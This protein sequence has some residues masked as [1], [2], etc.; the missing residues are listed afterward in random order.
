MAVILGLFILSRLWKRRQE[1]RA[2]YGSWGRGTRAAFF[3]V[4]ALLAV[5]A[6]AFSAKSYD[7]VMNDSRFCT[8]C[9]IFM[10]PGH[11]V[12]I[13]DTGDY[14]L[15]SRLSGKHDT[16]N[17]HTCH[18]FH[19]MSEA[20]KMVLWMSGFRYHE[21]QLNKGGAPAHG[22]VPRDVCE[23]CHVQGA[24]KETGFAPKMAS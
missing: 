17:C 19:A 20:R 16:L 7:Y 15:I 18:T 5:G 14:T 12:A 4:L 11:A 21:E 9:H 23:T 1:I 2:W 3:G 13:A 22:F 10:P 6:V 24:A 8:G